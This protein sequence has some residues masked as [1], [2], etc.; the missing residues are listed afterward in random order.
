MRRRHQDEADEEVGDR[1]AAEDEAHVQGDADRGQDAAGDDQAV[2]GPEGQPVED[3]L[4]GRWAVEGQ[5]KD[6]NEASDEEQELTLS[7]IHIS[8]PTRLGMISYAVFC[9]KK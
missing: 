4:D 2:D 9:L 3:I 6:R 5:Q 8:E 7:L 1:R